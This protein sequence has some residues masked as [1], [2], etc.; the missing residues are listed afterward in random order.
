[1]YGVISIHH[2]QWTEAYHR[3]S[4]IVRSFSDLFLFVASCLHKL[5]VLELYTRIS[6]GTGD[7]QC[8]RPVSSRPLGWYFVR[9]I[10]ELHDPIFE[11]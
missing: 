8:P 7:A 10:S 11:N 5:F 6:H 4:M 1:M 9:R 3:T 2:T